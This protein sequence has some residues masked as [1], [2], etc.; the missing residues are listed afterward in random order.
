MSVATHLGIRLGDYDAKIRTF[1]PDYEEMIEQAASMLRTVRRPSPDIVDLGVGS[2]ALAS[3]C[4]V[5]K[6]RARIAGVDLD[7]GILELARRRLGARLVTLHGSFL[8][9]PLPR[10]DA[11]TASFALHHIR[12]RA[13]KAAFYR[14]CVQALRPGG[15]LVSADC[16]TAANPRQRA[17][18]RAAWRAHLERHYS[19]A[20]ADRYLRAWAREDVYLTLDEELD[21]MARAGFRVDVAWRRRSF[22]VIVGTK[23]R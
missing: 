6:P 3:R 14:R 23:V 15:M 4:L 17:L 22:A 11:I 16:A 20:H 7:S 9:M 8:E 10:C 13:Q 12:T 18:D 19:R 2:G 1:I 5:T 21:L